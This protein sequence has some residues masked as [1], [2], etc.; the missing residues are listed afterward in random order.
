MSVYGGL[1]IQ[2]IADVF[3]PYYLEPTAE[4]PIL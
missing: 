1:Q 2:L 3:W 4:V